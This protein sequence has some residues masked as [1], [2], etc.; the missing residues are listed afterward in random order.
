MGNNKM[1]IY[2]ENEYLTLDEEA[3]MLVLQMHMRV[4]YPPFT[5][6]TDIWEVTG[7]IIEALR[8]EFLCIDLFTELSSFTARVISVDGTSWSAEC[9]SPH[10]AAQL[11]ALKAMGVVKNV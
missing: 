7:Q 9:A 4:A 6:R 10:L 5:H 2:T 11:A 8:R 1:N 3:R